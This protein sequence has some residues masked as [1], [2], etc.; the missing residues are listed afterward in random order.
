VPQ[1]AVMRQ[2][3]GKSIVYVVNGQNTVEQR[4]IDFNSEINGNYIIK[5]GV[6]LGDKVITSNLQ[7]I[8]PGA[9]V[10]PI[11]PETKK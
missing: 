4:V 11:A 5:S 2:T 8:G 9:P 6:K 10:T 1:E 3:N 7:K